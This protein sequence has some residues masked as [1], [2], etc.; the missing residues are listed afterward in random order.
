M[1]KKIL[2][3]A[4]SMVILL[5]G[6]LGVQA[7]ELK[8]EPYLYTEN[9]EDIDPVVRWTGGTYTVNFKGLTEEKAYSGK[10][11]FKLDLTLKE[12]TYF[13]W[14]IML[15]ERIPGEGKLN[16]SARVLLAEESTGIARLGINYFYPPTSMSG[17]GAYWGF[18]K[19]EWELVKGDLV[20]VVKRPTSNAVGLLWG[21]QVANISVYVD[22][23]GV[24]INDVAAKGKRWR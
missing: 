15:S 6:F 20:Q 7:E 18:S 3:G 11:S 10:K 5:S 21:T 12:G 23:I 4:V 19:G 8:M 22:R 1:L 9:F 2:A 24:F 14:S 17:C 13:Y 16:F